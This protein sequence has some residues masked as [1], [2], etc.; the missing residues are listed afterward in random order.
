MT[1]Y[2]AGLRLSEVVGL[3][4]SDIDSSRMLIR[5]RQGKGRKDRY[6]MLSPALL[7]LLRRYWRAAHP[8]DY[9]FPGLKNDQ[10][11][12]PASV[13]KACRRAKEASGLS[14]PVTPHVLRHCFATHLL[15]A[16]TDIRQ[17]QLL[18]GHKNV[19]STELY[20]HVSP[21]KAEAVASPL[22]KVLTLASSASRLREPF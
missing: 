17:I 19:R 20:T 15:E 18:L 8:T 3:R 7:E 22:D 4:V 16:G 5:V 12:N 11:L 14:K 2:S 9:L 6:V 21:Q 13:Q 10:P 1:A